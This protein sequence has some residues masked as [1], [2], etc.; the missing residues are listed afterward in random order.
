MHI[1]RYT[2]Y[3]LRV[4][5]YVGLKGDEIS[6]IREIA[7]S[8]G[9]SENHL[10]KVVQELNAHGYLVATRG[11]NGG[12]R[13]NGKPES[14]NIGALVR[15]T[16]QDFALVEC[17][18]NSNNCVLTPACQLKLILSEALENFFATLDGYS[19]ADLLTPQKQPQLA[20]LLHFIDPAQTV[21]ATKGR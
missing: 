18:G 6:T 1:T 7:D 12:V 10:M 8:Y 3:A 11:K 5:M 20:Q 4:L 16:E 13:L 14:I 15:H 2:D 21:D 17:M 19:L 9:I